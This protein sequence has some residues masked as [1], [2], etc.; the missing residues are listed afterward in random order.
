MQG[1]VVR[2]FQSL[3]ERA[4]GRP[5]CCLHMPCGKAQRRWRHEVHGD[6]FGG[7]RHKFENGRFSNGDVFF[8]WAGF[9]FCFLFWRG[10]FTLYGQTLKDISPRDIKTFKMLPETC[11]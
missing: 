1:E 4:Q 3:E 6:W 5:H 9:W 2:T 10:F 8:C 7:N 11:P